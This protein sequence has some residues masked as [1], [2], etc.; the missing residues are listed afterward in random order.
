MS[1]NEKE[2]KS[3]ELQ[4]AGQ[5]VS[6]KDKWTGLLMDV[7]GWA[8]EEDIWSWMGK[9]RGGWEEQLQ[10]L[11]S[12]PLM[13]MM[14]DA[15]EQFKTQWKRRWR[16]AI[17][18]DPER[19]VRDQMDDKEVQ[20]RIKLV[21]TA[22]FTLGIVMVM[23]AEFLLVGYPSG[24]PWFYLIVNFMLMLLRY[25]T[26]KAIKNHFFMLDFCYFLN[27][28]VLLQSLSCSMTADSGFCSTWFK[29]NFMLSHGPIAVA[30]LAWQNSIVFHSLDK[31]TSFFIHIMPPLTCY[32]QR[33]DVIPGSM[34]EEGLSL[35]LMQMVV[36]P[37]FWYSV[38]QVF[39]L[40]IQQTI[41]D[42]DPELMTSL[43]Y[44]TQ[45]PR[46]PMYIITMD[47]CIR[48]G[49]L[50]QGEKYTSEDTK[51]KIIYVV[52]QWV[53]MFLMLI[54]VPLY[55]Y[56]RF[57]NTTF[58]FILILAGIWRGGSYYIF[59]FSKSYNQKFNMPK[60]EN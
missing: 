57:L 25:L 2:K 28:S 48:L 11:R 26:Y 10:V 21:D 42:K 45:C 5:Q 18:G 20:K 51:T 27:A 46:N 36:I 56:F 31:M 23:I 6:L 1:E 49:V 60:K 44:L 22:S 59:K 19:R 13:M 35:S 4:E 24:F 12:A 14:M 50:K 16:E 37:M 9:V 17:T 41:I 58:L 7:L 40:Y 38:W 43:R 15:E 33:W 52:G 29:S 32:L 39:Y 54:P 3:D 30:I 53:Y 34:P 55:F 8:E 47:V